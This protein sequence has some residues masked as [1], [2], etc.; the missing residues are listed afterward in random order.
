[1]SLKGTYESL[2]KRLYLYRI[3]ILKKKKLNWLNQ[4]LH[5]DPK[6]K[7]EFN[8]KW[9]L[10]QLSKRSTRIFIYLFTFY[11]ISKKDLKV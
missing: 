11:S 10:G 4:V 1:M 5:N 7:W 3:K 2:K 9:K 8:T 6:H